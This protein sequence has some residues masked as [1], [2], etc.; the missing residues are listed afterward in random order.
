[1]DQIGHVAAQIIH[2][3]TAIPVKL[4]IV[5]EKIRHWPNAR[6]ALCC[7]QE[8][9]K[10]NK[11][12]LQPVRSSFGNYVLRPEPTCTS[13]VFPICS[14][15]QSGTSKWPLAASIFDKMWRACCDNPLS[16]IQCPRLGVGAKK[17][18]KK[19]R[20]VRVCLFA[21]V[22]D[23]PCIS[24]ARLLLC[25]SVATVEHP[26]IAQ[27]SISRLP[28]M[29][30]Y[31]HTEIHTE[32][33]KHPD[34]ARVQRNPRLS[35]GLLKGYSC[36]ECGHEKKM[37]WPPKIQ[38]QTTGRFASPFCQLD[39]SSRFVDNNLVDICFITE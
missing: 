16:W 21:Y 39:F 37:I 15:P 26:G 35:A 2:R 29:N 3:Y 10:E 38:K 7:Y 14:Q 17:K 8:T 9:K 24:I 6:N 5:L 20:C 25:Q 31:R 1:M 36:C 19:K 33:P 12:C 4:H 22:C 32:L 30:A 13:H 23:F 28:W 34:K 11:F 27:A 18:K